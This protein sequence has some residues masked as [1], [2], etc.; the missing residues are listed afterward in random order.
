M[1]Q[2]L[3]EELIREGIMN[4]KSK[5]PNQSPNPQ[6][7]IDGELQSESKGYL[8]VYDMEKIDAELGEELQSKF[9]VIAQNYKFRKSFDAPLNDS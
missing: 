5:V 1:I 6:N 8:G 2:A 7:S 3:D 4:P 9:S